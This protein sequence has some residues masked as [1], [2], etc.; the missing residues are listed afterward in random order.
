MSYYSPGKM[1]EYS[2]WTR[3]Q[4]GSMLEKHNYTCKTVIITWGGCRKT[5][6]S[7]TPLVKHFK[8]YIQKKIKIHIQGLPWWSS[9]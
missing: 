6:F 5:S 1:N 3:H 9:G 2:Y 4:H 8:K 7:M